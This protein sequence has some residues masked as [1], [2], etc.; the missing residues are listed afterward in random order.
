MASETRKQNSVKNMQLY[1]TSNTQYCQGIGC[2]YATMT[3][4]MRRNLPQEV[5]CTIINII[6]RLA[7]ERESEKTI[8]Q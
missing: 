8:E 7:D 2:Q 5:K 4:L 3:R 6:D 1:Y